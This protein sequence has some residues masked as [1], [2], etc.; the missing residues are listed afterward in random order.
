VNQLLQYIRH[1]SAEAFRAAGW[2]VYPLL[3]HHGRYSMLAVRDI[4]ERPK[5][6]SGG[7]GE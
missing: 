3:C 5:G 6:Q 1:D 2:R 4:Q 7:G